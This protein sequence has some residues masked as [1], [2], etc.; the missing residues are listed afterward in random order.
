MN[1]FNRNRSLSNFLLWL[2]G[3]LIIGA[4]FYELLSWL[5]DSVQVT[6]LLVAIVVIWYRVDFSKR[7][8]DGYVLLLTWAPVALGLFCSALW[9]I[10]GGEVWARLGIACIWVRAVYRFYPLP[11]KPGT[12]ELS[13]SFSKGSRP[14]AGS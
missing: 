2:L 1:L 13:L 5:T 12:Q 9:K 14:E 6:I 7:T 8:T 4:F 11:E 10:T 3:G